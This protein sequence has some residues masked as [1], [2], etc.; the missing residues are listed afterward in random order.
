MIQFKYFGRI[1]SNQNGTKKNLKQQITFLKALSESYLLLN[2]PRYS[3]GYCFWMATGFSHLFF[4]YG[5]LVD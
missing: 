3:K 2:A 1:L 4:W 5:Q